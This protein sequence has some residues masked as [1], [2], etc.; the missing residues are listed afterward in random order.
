[1]VGTEVDGKLT[2]RNKRIFLTVVR[3]ACPN[4]FRKK[5]KK[6]QVSLRAQDKG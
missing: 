4:D 1:L 6:N 3:F 2:G 5:T